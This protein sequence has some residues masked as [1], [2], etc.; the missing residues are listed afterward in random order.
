MLHPGEVIYIP[1]EA[2]EARG[3][4]DRPHV[5][6]NGIPVVDVE[7]A[8]LAYGSTRSTDAVRGAEHVLVEPAAT[9]YGG[10]GLM[11]PTYVYTSR[12]VSYFDSTMPPPA[13]R[14]VDE[15]PEIRASLARALGLV[16]GVTS[17][18]NVRGSNRRGRVVELVAELAEEWDVRHAVVIT[19]PS[20]SR[21]GFQQ[22]VV[23]LLDQRFEADDRDVLLQGEAWLA[24][25]SDCYREAI[26][27]TQMVSTVY[28]PVHITRF[29]D[30]VVPSTVMDRL[31]ESL[32]QHFGL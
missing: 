19:E 27:A 5:L 1:R 17:E 26:L 28:L 12:L 3:K 18:P 14:I 21:T 20:Y 7:R 4:G 25:I 30:I 29:L 2:G 22:L 8:T 31:D 15:M 16:C 23:P 9:P 11:R 24:H 10:T 6:L 13:G 32:A